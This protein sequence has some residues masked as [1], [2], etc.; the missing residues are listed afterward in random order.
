MLLPQTFDLN[1]PNPDGYPLMLHL[2][3]N[4]TPSAEI[5]AYLKSH[6]GIDAEITLD[7]LD[8]NAFLANEN[9]K[10]HDYLNEQ[11]YF[12]KLERYRKIP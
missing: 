2:N 3:F 1:S 8:L 7:G 6:Y 11:Y 12:S 9:F 4:V 10:Y 5:K